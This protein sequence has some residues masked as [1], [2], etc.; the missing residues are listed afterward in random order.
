[1]NRSRRS[2]I[3]HLPGLTLDYYLSPPSV[4]PLN[5]GGDLTFSLMGF[6]VKRTEKRI[7][8]ELGKPLRMNLNN[9]LMYP[10]TLHPK[11]SSQNFNSFNTYNIILALSK[12]NYK[13]TRKM[14]N[15]YLINI[16]LL[17]LSF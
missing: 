1:M 4:K 16:S 11:S 8:T 3:G 14:V 2:D 17:V 9:M 7:A 10:L 15:I 12:N 5:F 13:T 6:R